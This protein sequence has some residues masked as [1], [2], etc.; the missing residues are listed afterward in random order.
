MSLAYSIAIALGLVGF[1]IIIL[2]AF[3]GTLEVIDNKNEIARNER[4]S[5]SFER[6]QKLTKGKYDL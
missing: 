4:L 6:N 3:I 1:M 5:K 2:C